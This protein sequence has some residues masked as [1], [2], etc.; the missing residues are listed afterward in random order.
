V[1]ALSRARRFALGLIAPL[2][3]GIMARV[4]LSPPGAMIKRF[5]IPD[6]VVKEVYED[7]PE[8]AAQIRD[9]VG[10][11]RELCVELGL[12]NGLSRRV[13]KAMGI[14]DEPRAA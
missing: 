7:N 3:L 4:M 5:H 13:W 12:V 2:I 8:T 6:D 11:T 9:S 14:W 1:P 10:R